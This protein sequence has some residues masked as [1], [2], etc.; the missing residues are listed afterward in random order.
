MR[1]TVLI[2]LSALL[3]TTCEAR[4]Q[5]FECQEDYYRAS[6]KIRQALGKRISIE[7]R[8]GKQK[9]YDIFEYL[10]TKC[11]VPLCCK[12]REFKTQFGKDLECEKVWLREMKDVTCHEALEAI[13]R[14]I[15]ARYE[16]R[17]W[18]EID[19]C[20]CWILRTLRRV[21]F[22]TGIPAVRSW[23]EYSSP[24]PGETIPDPRESSGSPPP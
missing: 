12:L 4:C 8:E 9:L 24:R 6:E 17:G 10:A 14:Q 16:I 21:G 11:D 18:V 15:D 23:A 22:D 2:A 7:G 19:P 1:S 5:V 3:L 20:Q 13:L